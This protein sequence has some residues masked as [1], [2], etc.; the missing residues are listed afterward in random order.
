MQ[1][2]SI[3]EGALLAA[4]RPLTLADIAGLFGEDNQPPNEELRAAIEELRADCEGRGFSVH[5]VASGYRLQVRAELAPWLLKLSEEKPPK[6]SRATMETL[7]LI[8]Y[9]QPI[10]RGEIEEIRGV[11]VNP[12]IIRTLQEREWVRVVGHRDVPGRPELLATTRNF[13]DY[14]GLKSL[15]QLPTLSEIKDFEQINPELELA[16]VGPLPAV[17]VAVQLPLTAADPDAAGDPADA[18]PDSV[19]ADDD[20]G[21]AADG[22]E[23]HPDDF[24]DDPATPDE[25]PDMDDADLDF[26]DE[27]VAAGSTESADGPVSR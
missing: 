27:M 20:G 14:F 22:A 13:L 23:P 4:G 5:E 7:A 10:T 3:I 19:V 16:G 12:N 21:A 8:A 2:K 11:A 6:Y 18:P 9:R 24:D 17:P 1:L 25:E 26:E 15:D